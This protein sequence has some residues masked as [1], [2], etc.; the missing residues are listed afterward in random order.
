MR[1]SKQRF[2][3]DRLDY[4]RNALRDKYPDMPES[5]V[6]HWAEREG[7]QEYRTG[8]VYAD[9][10]Q[11][12]VDKIHMYDPKENFGSGDAT[13]MNLRFNP[14]GPMVSVMSL[15]FAEAKELAED[16]ITELRARGEW[17]AEDAANIARESGIDVP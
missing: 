10:V 16:I 6:D 1:P 14:A 11:I 9:P 3:A 7:E 5:V 17:R 4:H 13:G 15:S 8:R 12:E 2:I